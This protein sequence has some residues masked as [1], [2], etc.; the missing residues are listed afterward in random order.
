[1]RFVRNPTV[2]TLAAYRYVRVH[3]LS[4]VRLVAFVGGVIALDVEHAE[5]A[6]GKP[7]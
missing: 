7:R 5:L 2:A 4:G 1:V 3:N 6:H